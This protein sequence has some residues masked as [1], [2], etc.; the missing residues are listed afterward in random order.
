MAAAG[1]EEAVVVA[2]KAVDS[3]SNAIAA[4]VHTT[5]EL[6]DCSI[7][8]HEAVAQAAEEGEEATAA[9]FLTRMGVDS[10]GRTTLRC[11]S[12]C[13]QPPPG[14]KTVVAWAWDQ[15]FLASC[16]IWVPISINI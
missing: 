1:E 13:S 7:E 6:E 3:Q 2:A 16:S 15:I 14:G 10:T 9:K 11:W 4:I 12:C 5:D 8:W